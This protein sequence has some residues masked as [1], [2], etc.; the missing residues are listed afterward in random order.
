MK[1]G[2]AEFFVE[3]SKFNLAGICQKLDRKVRKSW[4]GGTQTELD[5]ARDEAVARSVEARLAL[6]VSMLQREY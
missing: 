1:S 2:I 4:C 3:T 5:I 6:P